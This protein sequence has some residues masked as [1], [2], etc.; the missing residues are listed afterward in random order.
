MKPHITIEKH[1]VTLSQCLAPITPEMH[2]WAEKNIFLKWGALSRGKF[3]CLD[4]GHAWKP[5]SE[6]ESAKFSKCTSCRSKLKIH[7]RN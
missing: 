5:R 7:G 4:S 2:S 6:K 3:H 1:I